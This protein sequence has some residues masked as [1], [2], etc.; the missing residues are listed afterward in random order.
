VPGVICIAALGLVTGSLLAA[1]VVYQMQKRA[2]AASADEIS[3]FST[4]N[5]SHSEEINISQNI[6]RARIV[7]AV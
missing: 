7:L 2:D 6:R 5:T 3:N 1:I 4:P